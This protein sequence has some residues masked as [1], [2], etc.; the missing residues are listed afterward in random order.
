MRRT[1]LGSASGAPYSNTSSLAGEP[2]AYALWIPRSD[3]YSAAV[4]SSL[5]ARRRRISRAARAGEKEEEGGDAP[6]A[7]LLGADVLHAL[8]VAL[9]LL[10][11]QL[12]GRLGVALNVD[13]TRL[14][15]RLE[16]AHGVLAL[17]GLLPNLDEL[18]LL[19][20]A[21]G[22]RLVDREALLSTRV[23][24]SSACAARRD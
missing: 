10:S 24:V 13:L 23:S 15:A 4:V 16:G 11:A 12:L 21:D 7:A 17:L 1:S 3:L 9:V 18:E 8:C 5:C 20:V 22:R 14:D 6:L 19:P 2:T